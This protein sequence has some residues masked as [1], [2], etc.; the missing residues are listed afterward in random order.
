MSSAFL[1]LQVLAFLYQGKYWSRFDISHCYLVLSKNVSFQLAKA[2]QF[3]FCY[4]IQVFSRWHGHGDR[5]SVLPSPSVA[6]RPTWLSNPWMAVLIFLVPYGSAGSFTGSWLFLVLVSCYFLMERYLL[7]TRNQKPTLEPLKFSEYKLNEIKRCLWTFF[8]ILFT[9]YTVLSHNRHRRR[10]FP[11]KLCNIGKGEREEVQKQ[12]SQTKRS[13]PAQFHL[14]PPGDPV[15]RG[16][17]GS[18]PCQLDSMQE[19]AL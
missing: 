18:R 14:P 3:S 16:K 8:H 13:N 9:L 17:A 19:T 7:P 6:L 12:K 15:G 2:V 11:L 1:K 5:Q 4:S 10:Q